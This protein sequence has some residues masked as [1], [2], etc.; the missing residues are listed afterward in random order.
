MKK[1]S[2]FVAALAALTMATSCSQ[3]EQQS[4]NTGRAISFNAA[5]DVTRGADMVTKNLEDNGFWAVALGNKDGGD[6]IYFNEKFTKEGTSWVSKDKHF[7]PEYDLKF[8]A[9]APEA[10]TN[11]FTADK[12]NITGFTVNKDI[13]KQIDLVAGYA[14]G[15]KTNNSTKGVELSLS[16]ALSKI[17]LKVK[18][19]NTAYKCVIKSASIGNLSNTGEFNIETAEWTKQ[20]GKDVYTQSWVGSPITIDGLQGTKDL[21]IDGGL[22]LMPQNITAWNFKKDKITSTMDGT[23]ICM[24][25]VLTTKAG[26]AVFEGNTYVPVPALAWTANKHYI[27][28]VDFTDGFGYRGGVDKPSEPTNPNPPID[29]GTD[30][31]KPVIDTKNPIKFINVQVKEWNNQ[32]QSDISGKTEDK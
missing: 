14:V 3:D 9:H 32:Q 27:Y 5:L 19:T 11:G 10:A 12:K 17:S 6:D 22:K 4:V 31:D 23:Y 24:Y 30:P 20:G 2:L 13:T 8:Y 25:I 15:N 28:T 26:A 29:P 18:G 1:K 16:H 7:W 21:T